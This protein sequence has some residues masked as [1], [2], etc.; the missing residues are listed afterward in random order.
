MP[1]NSLY[2]NDDKESWNKI[3][4]NTSG[5][6]RKISA[7]TSSITGVFCWFMGNCSIR[8][9]CRTSG[10]LLLHIETMIHPVNGNE[11]N[12]PQPTYLLSHAPDSY[13]LIVTAVITPRRATS[14]YYSIIQYSNSTSTYKQFTYLMIT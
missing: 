4:L 12:L 3:S 14:R 9:A 8:L 2:W 10:I 1:L 5:I 13:N 6:L 11:V 7:S